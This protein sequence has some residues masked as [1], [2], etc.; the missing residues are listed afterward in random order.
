MPKPALKPD[1]KDRCYVTVK[2]RR[3]GKSKCLTVYDIRPDRL[4]DLI[5]KSIKDAD[6]KRS[7]ANADAA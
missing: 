3:T 7:P 6:D 4:I 1:A 5:R 2:D